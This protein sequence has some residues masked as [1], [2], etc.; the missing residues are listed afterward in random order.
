L[1]RVGQWPAKRP[2]FRAPAHLPFSRRKHEE[3]SACLH[4]VNRARP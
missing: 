4:A 1:T 2:Y 3:I